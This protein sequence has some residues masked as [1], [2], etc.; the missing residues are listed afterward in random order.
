MHNNQEKL[1]V[2]TINLR[3]ISTKVIEMFA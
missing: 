2:E 3:D 1:M